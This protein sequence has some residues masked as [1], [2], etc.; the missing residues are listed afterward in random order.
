MTRRRFLGLS[1]WGRIRV[2]LDVA[3]M[4][5]ESSRVDFVRCEG[6]DWIYVLSNKMAWIHTKKELHAFVALR[7]LFKQGMSESQG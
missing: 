5:V 3:A 1:S 7:S 2:L 4:V 6:G